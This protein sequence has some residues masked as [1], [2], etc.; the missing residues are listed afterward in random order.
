MFCPDLKDGPDIFDLRALSRST[1]CIVIIRPDQYVA[2]IL[3]LDAHDELAA[4]FNNLF[5]PA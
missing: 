1:G 5:L 2:Q 4:F 3:P